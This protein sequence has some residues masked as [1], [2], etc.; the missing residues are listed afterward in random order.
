MTAR[1]IHDLPRRL[2][3]S[4][5]AP[6]QIAAVAVTVAISALDGYDVLAASFA[7]PAVS[8]AWGIGKATLGLVLS[9]G[10][11]GMAFGA[12]AL[13]PLADLVGRRALILASLAVM[14]LGMA[15]SAL[16]P[17]PACLAAWRFLTGLGIG[18]MVAV[19]TPLAA[20]F[21]N[22]RR[23][24]LALALMAMGYPAGGLFG[25]AAAAYLLSAFG[26]RAL[27]W[28]GSAAA[29]CLLPAVLLFLPEPMVFLLA[30][31]GPGSLTRVNRL[32]KR[33]GQPAVTD[34]PPAA[35]G[36]PRPYAQIFAPGVR[37]RTVQLT[38]VS[39]TYAMVAYY[40][41][42]W[43]PQMV[44]DAGFAPATAS[45]A[46]AVNGAAGIGGGVMLGALAQ[47]QGLARLTSAA[48]AGV[49]V[50]LVAFGFSPPVLPLL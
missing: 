15:L 46:S 6:L 17:S 11:F 38:A 37:F 49:G 36:G 25:G 47:R 13:A 20:E 32:L 35:Q 34:L 9:S 27:F 41:L 2:D 39:V 42:S 24:P 43:L 29:L 50:A 14:A 22:A 1:P 3:E 10:L 18:A 4:P 7:A 26:W 19:I 31:R 5:M 40:M 45:L 28:L 33:F 23:R 48:M 44:A 21:A 16:A 12:L 8:R 30:R